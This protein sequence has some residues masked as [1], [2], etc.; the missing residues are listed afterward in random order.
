[1]RRNDALYRM[2][3]TAVLLAVGLVLPFLTGQ[4]Q[5]IGQ[6]ISPLHIPAFICGL[7]C[8]PVWGGLLGAVLPLMRM[9]LFGMPPLSA[10]LPMTFELCAYGLVTGLMYP[11]LC[12]GL[13]R[14]LPAMLGAL[15]AAMIAGRIIG[16]AAKALLLISGAISGNPLTLQAFITGYFVDTAVGALIH[17]VVV[18]AVVAALEKA[19][20]SPL[21]RNISA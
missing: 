15:I 21:S 4:L 9:A 8:G 10:A 3:V 13:R 1:M 17:L 5:S 20:I 19:R 14:R 11:A 18:P 12:R 7:T 6:L 16:G 2:V